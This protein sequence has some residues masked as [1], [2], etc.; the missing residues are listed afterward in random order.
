VALLAFDDGF[1]TAM[2][3]MTTVTLRNFNLKSVADELSELLPSTLADLTLV[4]TL[5][6]AM[7][8]D[9]SSFTALTSLYV[10]ARWSV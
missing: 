7:P 2:T 5:F 8:A 6:Y 1:L 9:L 4:N 3:N 10:A